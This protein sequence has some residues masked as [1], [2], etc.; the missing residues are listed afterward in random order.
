[1]LLLLCCCQQ[2]LEEKAA[3]D[4]AEYNRRYCPT[5]VVN[6]QRTDS[7]AFH[8][9]SRTYIYYCTFSDVLDNAEVLRTNYDKIRQAMR[10]SIYDNTSMKQYVEAGFRFRFVCRSQSNP[11]QVLMQL[12]IK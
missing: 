3:A 12:D 9:A 6:Y 11:K 5:P 1:M 7:V 4:A 2:S 10:S 8:A